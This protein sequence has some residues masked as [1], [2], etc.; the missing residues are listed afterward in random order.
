MHI[1]IEDLDVSVLMRKDDNDSDLCLYS[2]DI[3]DCVD[4]WREM[5]HV[6]NQWYGV[7]FSHLVGFSKDWRQ[8]C[9]EKYLEWWLVF[10]RDS[11][12]QQ[13]AIWIGCDVGSED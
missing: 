2:I 7:I 1:D 5:V 8:I 12:G 10:L 6:Y 3:S 11:D 9:W 4:C 13:R